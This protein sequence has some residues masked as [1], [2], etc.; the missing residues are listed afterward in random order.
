MSYLFIIFYFFRAAG[1][2]YGSSQARGRLGAT[3]ASLCHSH[4]N[5][6]Y[7]RICDLRHNSWQ[8]WILNPLSEAR[9]QPSILMDTGQVCNLLNHNGNSLD[10]LFKPLPQMQTN[11][12]WLN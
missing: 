7:S 1:V 6:R 5:V 2:A 10:F 11:L 8:H 3:A 9:D 4:S 12:S